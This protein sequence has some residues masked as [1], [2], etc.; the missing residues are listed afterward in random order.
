MS[1]PHAT[2][3]DQR[4]IIPRDTVP[5]QESD[6]PI[7]EDPSEPAADGRDEDESIDVEDLP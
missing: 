2:P 7:H 6:D 5:R 1:D 4:P 3:E